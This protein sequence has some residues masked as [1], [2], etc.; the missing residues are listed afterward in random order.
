MEFL[1][2]YKSHRDSLSR[3]YLFYPHKIVIFLN[4]DRRHTHTSDQL[5][6]LEPTPADR[7]ALHSAPL[8]PRHTHEMYTHT[9][10]RRE[11]RG[12]KKKKVVW[13]AV[14]TLCLIS[15]AFDHGLG[16]VFRLGPKR[17]RLV[18]GVYKTGRIWTPAT[19]ARHARKRRGIGDFSN[20]VCS[21]FS[22]LVSE[23]KKKFEYEPK[24]EGRYDKIANHATFI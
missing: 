4:G 19:H 11:G 14:V 15:F 7:R 6:L 8:K 20:R 1:T 21:Y 18:G 22:F 3:R 10:T 24:H 2:N 12:K 23:I 16:E 9:H 13:V 5:L 17:R